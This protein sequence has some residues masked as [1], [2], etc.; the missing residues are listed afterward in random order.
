[1]ISQIVDI[2]QKNIKGGILTDEEKESITF[3]RSVMSKMPI[4]I[5]DSSANTVYKNARFALD[6]IDDG[7]LMI[8]YLQLL[9]Q[10]KEKDENRNHSQFNEAPAQ[11]K[12]EV[13]SALK[14][15]TQEKR[16][17]VVVCSQLARDIDQRQNKRPILQYLPMVQEADGVIFLYRDSYYTERVNEDAEILFAKNRDGQTGTAYVKFDNRRLMFKSNC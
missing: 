5:N 12:Y 10:T 4:Y 6:E 8:D 7:I 14:S 2:G 11:G 17:P 3:C 9:Q 16:I 1:M 15:L 13:I